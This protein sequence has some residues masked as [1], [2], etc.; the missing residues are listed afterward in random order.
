METKE[1]VVIVG[2]GFAGL[3]CAKQLGGKK[4]VSVVLV[5]RCNFHLFQPLLYQVATAALNPADIAIPIRAI[6]SSYKNIEVLMG[7]VQTISL[8]DQKISVG[9]QQLAYDYLILAC[10]T[11]N[12]YFGHEN[13]APFAPGLKSIP[14]ALDIRKRILMAYE[15]AEMEQDPEK[16]RELLTFIVVGGGPT[17]VEMA[18][19][20]AEIS[21]Q[22]LLKDF[23]HIDPRR[24][25]VILL[26][27]APRILSNYS[28]ETSQRA[29]SDLESL[30]SQVWCN[31]KVTD[32][33]QHGVTSSTET[34]RSA[35]V[36]WTAGVAA[37][38]VNQA[39]GVPL[40]QRGLVIVE[41]DLSLKSH[42]EVFVLG[43]QAYFE[44]DS[45]KALPGLAPVALQQGVHAAKNILADI[46]KLPRRPFHYFDRGQ[47]ATIGKKKAVA[48][49]GRWEFAGPFAWLLWLVIHIYFLI[50]FKNRI[51]V[52]FQWAW[53]YFTAK[54]GARLI[55]D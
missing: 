14:E 3:H 7:E 22:T 23:R 21:R 18:G 13:W 31:F 41:K 1:K 35:T 6:L 12:S 11:Q 10:G 25:R 44:D 40:T 32:I 48:K 24:A 39:L 45:G 27:A 54:R 4:N 34:I 15:K 42:P 50:G 5:D 55:V 47:M 43:D 19:A 26:E 28:E 9:E 16:Q 38:P 37:P 53:I 30:G 49:I 8:V 20:I 52:I 33:N 51:M 29:V 17:G 2:G 46:R 36:V